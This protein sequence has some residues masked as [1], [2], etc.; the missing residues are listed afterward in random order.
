MCINRKDVEAMP[1][2][3]DFRNVAASVVNIAKGV[4]VVFQWSMECFFIVPQAVIAFCWSLEVMQVV[5]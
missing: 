4:N 3:Y 5:R 2:W 1:M